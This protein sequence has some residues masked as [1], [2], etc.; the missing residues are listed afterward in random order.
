MNQ[1]LI[2]Q[3]ASLQ[4]ADSN[5][6]DG[7]D[8]FLRRLQQGD[9]RAWEQLTKELVPLLYN[10]LRHNLPT[11][12]DVED[13]LSET[14][15]AAVRA[16]SSFDGKVT[17]RTFIYSLAR[18]KVADFWRG[19]QETSELKDSVPSKA[20]PVP[21]HLDLEDALRRLPDEYRQALLLRHEAG[22]SVT[23]IADI[24]G[25]TYK[26]TESLLSRARARLLQEL[27]AGH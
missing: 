1:R 9:N 26:A 10:Y 11:A 25:R 13:V 4:S 5:S 23:E 6:P 19:H 17:I 8:E 24:F 20:N 7:D 21:L 22:F 2:V 3:D 16:L 15:V 14:M 12:E 27:D 18:R